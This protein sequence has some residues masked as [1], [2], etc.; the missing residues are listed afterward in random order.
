MDFS[1]I[2][3]ILFIIAIGIYYFFKRSSSSNRDDDY[4]SD[5]NKTIRIRHG[6]L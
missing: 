6:N 3:L 2:F 4:E 1:I 5:G